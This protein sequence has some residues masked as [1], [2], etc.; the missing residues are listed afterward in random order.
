[1]LC[2]LATA[3]VLFPLLP[4]LLTGAVLAFLSEPITRWL[5]CRF[6]ARRGSLAATSL[7]LFTILLIAG[8]F[9]LPFSVVVIGTLERISESVRA[10]AGEGSI[11]DLIQSW[12]QRLRVLPERFS[13]P[14]EPGQLS[15][16]LTQAAQTALGWLGNTTGG[17]VAQAPSAVFF[18]TLALISWGYCLWKGRFLRIQVLRFLLPWPEERRTLRT[19]FAAMLKSLV[20]ANI[21]VSLIQAGIIG[22]FLAFTGVPH[23]FLWTSLAFFA[24]FIPVV[25]TLPVTLGGALWCWTVADSLP[26]TIALVVCAFIAGTADNLLRPFLARGAGALDSFWLFLAILGGLAQFG[27]AGFILGPLA[28]ALCLASASTLRQKLKTYS[29]ETPS[30]AT[31]ENLSQP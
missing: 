27:V 25:G 6:K 21:L 20:A 10:L 8:L 14:V 23:A 22:L 18:A 9:L 28:L 2:L 4:P 13:I 11:N 26:R 15:N 29:S 30:C 16:L 3:W 24:S 19:T 1:M 17:L 12:I 5:H 31:S 7:S